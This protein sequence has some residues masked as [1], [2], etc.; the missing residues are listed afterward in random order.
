[1][2]YKQAQLLIV[3]L[4]QGMALANFQTR[5]KTV[6]TSTPLKQEAEQIL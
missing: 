5:L 6:S 2:Q 4:P 1:L 3:S